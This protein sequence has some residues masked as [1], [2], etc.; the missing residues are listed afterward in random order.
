MYY[1]KQFWAAYAPCEA[2]F[3]DAVQIT[4]EQIDVIKRLT[5]RYTP[6]LTPCTTALG[7]NE[8]TI[9]KGCNNP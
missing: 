1:T 8:N 6:Q 9:L 3:K 7:M 5:E 4:I 2:Q